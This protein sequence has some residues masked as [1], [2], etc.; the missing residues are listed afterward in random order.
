MGALKKRESTTGSR[1]PQ[2]R[3]ADRRTVLDRI[4]DDFDE[5]THDCKRYIA[6]SPIPSDA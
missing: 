6:R 5:S 4:R 1:R 3:A 2:R